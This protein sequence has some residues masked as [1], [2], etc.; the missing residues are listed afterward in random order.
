MPL[1]D[2]SCKKCGPFR[3]WQSMGRSSEPAVCP[4]CGLRSVR[5]IVAP[6]I[7]D[8]NPNNRIAHQRN[9]KSADEPRVINKPAPTHGGVGHS[10][11]HRHG[12]GGRHH[13]HGPSR[14]W[15]IGH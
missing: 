3:D 12:A 2:Y 9:E 4:S 15:M 14:P 1:Y 8:M 6:F 11:P 10:H 7:A 5:A 13:A